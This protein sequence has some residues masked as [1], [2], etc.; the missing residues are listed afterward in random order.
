VFTNGFVFDELPLDL[1]KSAIHIAS[2]AGAAICFD[3]GELH[4]GAMGS[5]R[6]HS[7]KPLSGTVG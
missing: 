4:Q 3:P 5:I 7:L 2:E 6:A 1:V